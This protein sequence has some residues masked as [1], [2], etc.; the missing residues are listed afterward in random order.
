MSVI[1]Q[2][3]LLLVASEKDLWNLVTKISRASQVRSFTSQRFFLPLA[4]STYLVASRAQASVKVSHILGKT[5]TSQTCL[6][7]H[8]PLWA[9]V[10]ETEKKVC[11][12][13]VM[14]ETNTRAWG[15]TQS[16]R[17]RGG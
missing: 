1:L 13:W 9:P 17:L 2:F 7:V 4:E 12:L 3:R 5:L 16:R 14:L 15:Q 6:A 8:L 10:T 11:S